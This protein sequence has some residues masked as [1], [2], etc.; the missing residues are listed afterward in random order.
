MYNITQHL[1]SLSETRIQSNLSDKRKH[2]VEIANEDG[3]MAKI[4]LTTRPKGVPD[5][6]SRQT[7][8]VS[9]KTKH[10]IDLTVS[11]TPTA[12]KL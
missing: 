9:L 6:L 1:L 11:P 5:V 4:S 2:P 10:Y 7:L 8:L 12:G 3:K